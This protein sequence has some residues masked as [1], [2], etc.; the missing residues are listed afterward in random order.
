MDEATTVAPNTPHNFTVSDLL[1]EAEAVRKMTGMD[2]SRRAA[3]LEAF[4]KCIRIVRTQQFLLEEAVSLFCVSG[5][6]AS[7]YYLTALNRLRVDLPSEIEP[8]TNMENLPWVSKEWGDQTKLANGHLSD[9]AVATMVRSL[10]R[11]SL[12]FEPVLVSARDR[13]MHL[14]YVKRMF[15]QATQDLLE[16]HPGMDTA[17]ATGRLKE[18]LELYR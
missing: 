5:R 9:L 13:I 17:N 18:L 8:P 14:S 1:E 2:N 11:D 10:L 16:A 7:L 12:A 15:V 6:N 3:Q 4:A